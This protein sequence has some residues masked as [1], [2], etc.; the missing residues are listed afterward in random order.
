MAY[1][2]KKKSTLPND[3]SSGLIPSSDLKVSAFGNMVEKELEEVFGFFIFVSNDATGETRVH[4]Q[5]FFTCNGMNT[6]NRMLVNDSFQSKQ[7]A[8]KFWADCAD[9]VFY[10]IPSNRTMALSRELGLI[11]SRV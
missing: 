2:K 9:L 7:I 6:N 11:N 8:S 1:W 3:Y 10:R 4:I 5:S